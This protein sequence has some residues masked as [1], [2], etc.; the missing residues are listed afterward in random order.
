MELICSNCNNPI[1]PENINIKTDLAKCQNC[2]AIYKASELVT[3]A[4]KQQLIDPPTDSKIQFQKGLSGSIEMFLPA[5]GWSIA[6]APIFAFALFWIGFVAF[7]TYMASQ[8]SVL[9]AMFSIPFWFVGISMLVGIVNS[10]KSTETIK[11]ERN[12]IVLIKNKPLKKSTKEIDLKE[13]KE[14]DVIK[15]SGNPFK[16]M[17]K[18]EL[19]TKK[20]RSKEVYIP[21][22][23][24][25][26]GTT[27]FFETAGEKDQQ[28]VAHTLN[29]M[30]HKMKR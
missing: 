26:N 5:N 29:A 7:W 17:G 21:A 11:L 23:I 6:S 30:L 22:I 1:S 10:A 12:K 14:I 9:F 25:N 24:S 16:M 28:W 19:N 27:Y 15:Y 8:A 4:R 18:L 3:K 13:V 2:N 20:H